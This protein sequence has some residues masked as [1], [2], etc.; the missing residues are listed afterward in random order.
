M[1]TPPLSSMSASLHRLDP[2]ALRP[3][4]SRFLS[5]RA[6]RAEGVPEPRRILL[7]GHSHQAWPDVAREA[8]IEAFDDAALHVDDKWDRAFAAL[9]EVRQ[10]IAARIGGHADEYAFAP[11]THELVTRFLSGLDLRRRPHVVTT[12]GEFH[13]IRRQLRRLA[14]EGI[15]VTWVD[16]HPVATLAERLAAALR[17]TTAALLASTVLFE[18][19]ER[20]PGL[21]QLTAAA[22]KKGI[23]VLYDAYH[24]FTTVPFQ[25]ADLGTD[26]LY[27][28]AGGYK[29]AQWGEGVCFLRVPRGTS[30]RPVL[31]GWF[32]DFGS[33]SAPH[34]TGPVQYGAAG[35]S[36]FAGS[37]F[38]PISA[39]RARAVCRF[40]ARQ[41]MTV[42]A[43][44][45]LSVQQT[46]RLYARLAGAPGVVLATPADADA[47]GAFLTLRTP[48]AG[49]VVQALRGE[50]VYVDS[51]R[52][53]L[54]LGPAPYITVEEI[55]LAAD[56]LLRHL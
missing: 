8:L 10:V 52:D 40:F 37:T 20:V 49:H 28:V 4:Y 17:D 27:V 5:A 9:S 24:A 56:L 23:A 45:A 11:N 26:P 33:L 25:V 30:L 29:Y 16:A 21:S 15:E 34:A 19:A 31:T 12:S 43:L 44:R 32:A 18:T 35:E 54:R 42:P 1:L 39:Y 41:E 14:E 13:S 7:T 51:R 47:R 6:N 36:R 2:A 46:T 53:L 22:Q 50:G 55:D 38:D 3:H 48:R